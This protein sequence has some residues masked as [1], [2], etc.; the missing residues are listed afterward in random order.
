MTAP[1]QTP[2]WL[3]RTVVV[4]RWATVPLSV[5]LSWFPIVF[6][7]NIAVIARREPGAWIAMSYGFPLYFG[8]WVLGVA[9]AIG[10]IR[11]GGARWVQVV[12]VTLA[13]LPLP[14]WWSELPISWAK[15]FE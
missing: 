5:F 7:V 4:V 8:S 3:S 12:V 10:R 14:L 11:L 6:L 15:Y 13:V 2:P 9:L 1:R